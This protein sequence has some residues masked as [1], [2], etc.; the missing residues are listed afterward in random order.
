MS[1]TARIL[2]IPRR[3]PADCPGIGIRAGIPENC[4]RRLWLNQRKALGCL[5]SDGGVVLQA[6]CSDGKTIVSLVGAIISCARRP[7][8]LVPSKALA[9]QTW[10]EFCVWWL[11]GCFRSRAIK[12]WRDYFHIQSHDWIS[13]HPGYL[14]ELQPDYIFADEAHAFRRRE[15]ARHKR[16]IRYLLANPP[17]AWGG[18]TTFGIASGTLA[19][20]TVL[21]L[22]PLFR[23]VLGDGSP[24]PR[25]G[26]ELDA[27]AAML[28]PAGQP[29]V[30][31]WAILRPLIISFTGS[32]PGQLSS[33]RIAARE[34]FDR[35]R[36]LTPGIVVSDSDSV[37]CSLVISRWRPKVTSPELKLA[38]ERVNAGTHPDGTTR[39]EDPT[40]RAKI[41]KSVS[42]GYYYRWAWERTELGRPDEEWLSARS[43]WAKTIRT[44]LRRHA[45][46][47]YDSPGL[48]GLAARAPESSLHT[49]WMSWEQV[50]KRYNEDDLREAVW[51]SNEILEQALD[52][53]V[54]T[55]AIIWY[56]SRA[57]EQRL[58]MWQLPCFG[59]G[60]TLPLDTRDPYT[61]GV[62]VR[63]HGMGVDGLQNIWSS[64]LYLEALSSGVTWE[65]SLARVHRAGQKA[66]VVTAQVT[67]HTPAMGRAFRKAREQALFLQSVQGRQRLCYCS[68]I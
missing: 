43:A 21:E 3:A 42:V 65:Q 24:L 1:E 34:A 12:D 32:Q 49:T 52:E 56:S 36:R 28:D 4:A 46:P 25:D 50:R 18:Q 16:L 54:K 35:R 67:V 7:L 45:G 14:D 63:V 8:I 37:P 60:D 10:R 29:W 23:L 27:W 13:T 53:A 66:D 9:R 55:S 20:S 22:S 40:E 5:E 59:R 15:S 62:S 41:A 33:A 38:L 64:M 17:R 30:Q 58:R 2:N 11:L 51:I 61:C 6:G 31:H 57:V 26:I 19:A 44:E 68:I 48:I 39:L 47:Y